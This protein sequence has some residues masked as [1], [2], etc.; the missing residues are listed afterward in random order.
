MAELV[1]MGPDIPANLRGE[2]VW[3]TVP[4]ALTIDPNGGTWEGSPTPQTL[5]REYGSQVSLSNP[6]R[7]ACLF[8]GWTTAQDDAT[9]LV[10]M[11][12]SLQG[13]I[14]LHALWDPIEMTGTGDPQNQDANGD[15]YGDNI[16]FSVPSSVTVCI[17]PDGT[18]VTPTNAEIRN[19]SDFAIRVSSVRISAVSPYSL[20]TDVMASSVPNSVS[21]RFGARGSSALLDATGYA[22][23]ASLPTAAE[24]NVPANASLEIRFDGRTGNLT[25]DVTQGAR[26]FAI[27][28]WYVRAGSN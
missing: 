1:A 3:E 26:D 22:S 16:A 13:D 18:M 14:V 8:R 19:H 27:I 2:W 20:V 6:V 25:Q 12:M 24:W 10:S 15:G 11:P 23:K 28:D 9:T 5:I 7:P 17:R 21:I 4:Y